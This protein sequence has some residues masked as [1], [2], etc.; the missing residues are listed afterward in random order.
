MS[1]K[2]HRLSIPAPY[3]KIGGFHTLDSN[4]I[5]HI[6]PVGRLVPQLT[7][8]I[9]ENGLGENRGSSSGR[10]DGGGRRRHCDK[11][12]RVEAEMVVEG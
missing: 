5:V 2:Q 11:R 8:A 7:V 10:D 9:L 1:N 6:P 4:P 3:R 12:L